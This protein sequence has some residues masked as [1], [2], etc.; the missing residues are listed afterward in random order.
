MAHTHKTRN[1]P[2]VEDAFIPYIQIQLALL[3]Y[4]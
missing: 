1:N 2:I 4:F 3:F